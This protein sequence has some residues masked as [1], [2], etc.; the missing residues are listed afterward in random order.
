[1]SKSGKRFDVSQPFVNVCKVPE[2]MFPAFLVIV[3][4]PGKEQSSHNA[5][6]SARG[7]LFFLISFVSA[8]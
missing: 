6:V 4:L 5:P 8:S 2:G 1:L 7:L 3:R